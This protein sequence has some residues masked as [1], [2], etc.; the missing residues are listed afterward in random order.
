MLPIF[1]G[2]LETFNGVQLVNVPLPASFG[3]TALHSNILVAATQL[4][5]TGSPFIGGV[6]I[7]V[8]NIAP[9]DNGVKVQVNVLW[10]SPIE[11]R[12]AFVIW[13]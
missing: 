7:Q 1:F 13:P 11:I 8:M 6:S 12:L 5:G 9:A 4:D 3:V 2:T 10:D